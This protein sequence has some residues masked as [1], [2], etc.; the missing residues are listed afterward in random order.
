MLGPNY[1]IVR[2]SIYDVLSSLG[3]PQE[4]L[5]HDP[6]LQVGLGGAYDPKHR[7]QHTHMLQWFPVP[8]AK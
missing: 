5:P 2:V 8:L 7:D 3:L 6:H 4:A 1:L